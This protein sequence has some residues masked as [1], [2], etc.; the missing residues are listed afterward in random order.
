[1]NIKGKP[2]LAWEPG[3][4]YFCA[5]NAADLWKMGKIQTEGRPPRA[6]SQFQFLRK[7]KVPSCEASRA[8]CPWT[9]RTGGKHGVCRQY[10]RWKMYQCYRSTAFR[11]SSLG[12]PG[13]HTVDRPSRQLG[14]APP[15]IRFSL[16]P[17][18]SCPD[19]VGRHLVM[20]LSVT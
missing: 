9:W 19:R 10:G 2:V 15:W 11:R 13:V 7:Q 5:R 3:K 12:S 1:M 16:I 18:L 6:G 14:E 17:H 8:D 4:A 20:A